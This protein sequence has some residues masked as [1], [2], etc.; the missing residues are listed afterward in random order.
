MYRSDVEKLFDNNRLIV[1]V[2]RRVCRYADRKMT[3]QTINLYY[4]NSSSYG[5]LSQ[6]SYIVNI[7]SFQVGVNPF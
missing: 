1:V 2:C 5:D 7:A 4:K 3:I 6:N